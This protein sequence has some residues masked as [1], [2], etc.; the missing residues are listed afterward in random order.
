MPTNIVETYLSVFQSCSP[1]LYHIHGKL[2]DKVGSSLAP[3]SRRHERIHPVIICR[4][5]PT[6]RRCRDVHITDANKPMYVVSDQTNLVISRHLA[7]KWICTVKTLGL[8]LSR[9]P[10]SCQC[11]SLFAQS[12]DFFNHS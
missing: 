8:A 6:V 3:S 11:S 10:L 4:G 1:S 12:R 7:F 9:A 2:V 5:K